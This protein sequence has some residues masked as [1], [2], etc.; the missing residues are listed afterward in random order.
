MAINYESKEDM[1]YL[2]IAL[3]EC[4]GIGAKTMFKVKNIHSAGS[5]AGIEILASDTNGVTKP[6]ESDLEAKFDVVKSR[7]NFVKLRKKRDKLLAES[8]WS[9]GGDVPDALKTK[10]QTYRQNLR[11]IPNNQTP[12][13]M[14]LTNI[15]WPTKPS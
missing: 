1:G 10:W 14:F 13:D 4:C 9:Q 3:R 5:Y 15:T 6:S 12:T 11:D 2:F 8:D 7:E